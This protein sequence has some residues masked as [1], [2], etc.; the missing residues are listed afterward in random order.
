MFTSEEDE[1]KTLERYQVRVD[2]LL[3]RQ[4]LCRVHLLRRRR[5]SHHGRAGLSSLGNDRGC[6][7]QSQ[8]DLAVVY[9]S[10]CSSTSIAIRPFCVPFETLKEKLRR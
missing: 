10:H 2:E 8:D 4:V 6:A 5:C 3:F 9:Y 1:Q 7:G